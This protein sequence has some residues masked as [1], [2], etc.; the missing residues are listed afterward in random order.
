ME[1]CGEW[2]RIVDNYVNTQTRDGLLDN[3]VQA[4]RFSDFFKKT[5]HSIGTK[6]ELGTRKF[7]RIRGNF[8]ESEEI[9]EKVQNAFVH[10][11]I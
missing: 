9:P 2:W 1:I 6:A 8:G 7:R 11:M 10:K 4:P 5:R 3:Q